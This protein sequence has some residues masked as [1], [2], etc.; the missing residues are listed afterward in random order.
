M[1]D[2]YKGIFA[3]AFCSFALLTFFLGSA[4]TATG[5]FLIVSAALAYVFVVK[6]SYLMYSQEDRLLFLVAALCGTVILAFFGVQI[7][8]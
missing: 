4:I 2:L 5:L 8:I 3:L 1:N 6:P 7:W